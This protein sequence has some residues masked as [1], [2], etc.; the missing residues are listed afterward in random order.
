MRKILFHIHCFW[1]YTNFLES[2]FSSKGGQSNTRKIFVKATGGKNTQPKKMLGLR[3]LHIFKKENVR[4]EIS[5][6]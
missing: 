6:S 2:N 3:Y 5:S 4:F 1:K